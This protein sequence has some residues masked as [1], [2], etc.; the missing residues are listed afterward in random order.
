MTRRLTLRPHW[1]PALWAAAWLACAAG[2]AAQPTPLSLAFEA[3]WTRQPE[4]AALPLRRD[5][6]QAQRDA[7][8][9]W[10][11][12]PPAL[13]AEAKTDRWSSN[14][15]ARE[16]NLGVA[17]PLWLPGERGG[18]QVLADA[19]AALLASQTQAA[20]LRLA[21]E[22]REAW[23]RWQR[24]RAEVAL[25]RAQL[26]AAQHLATDVARRVQAGDL[27]RADQHQAEGAL[28]AAQAELADAEASLAEAAVPVQVLTGALPAEATEIAPEAESTP[29]D[30]APP[31]THALLAEWRDR[32]AVAERSAALA[33][34]QSRANPELTLT[35]T[36]D[37]GAYGEA[38]GQT[39]ALGLRVPF[40]AGARHSAQVAGA[41]AD[42]VEAQ[43]QL[44]QTRARLQA[45]RD[46]AR[47]RVA[48]A[49]TQRDAAER[50]A[51]L[52][53]EVRG[54]YDRSFALGEA[55]LP[56]RL[57]V[58]A[59][60]TLAERLAARSRID[61]AAAIS[62]WRQALGLLPQ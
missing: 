43:A 50:R 6:A 2:A 33:R 9:A 54:F 52:A 10:T 21:A 62:T 49:R 57:R 27:A 48:A 17:V 35:A 55:D 56:T 39:L 19:Q 46:A 53:R 44:A 40:G 32:A 41:R 51:E 12:A 22:L 15:G 23:W 20:Q 38:Y 36:R 30:D 37:R 58:Q 1:R 25:A 28:A 3:A 16:L 13:E 47:Q 4:A 7:A 5:A 42:A 26:E 11:P 31:E 18:S 8:S 59:E 45:E 60:A 14:H 29:P 24:S 61:L 34:L